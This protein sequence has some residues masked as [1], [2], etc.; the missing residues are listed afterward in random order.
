MNSDNKTTREK[1]A[2]EFICGSCGSKFPAESVGKKDEKGRPLCIP[3]SLR[4]TSATVAATTKEETAEQMARVEASLEKREKQKGSQRWIAALLLIAIPVIAIEVFMLLKNRPAGLTAP[5]VAEIEL[6][7]CMIMMTIL[8]QYYDEHGQYPPELETLVPEFW[9][10]DLANELDKF[11]YTP[12]GEDNFRLER[13]GS[14]LPP[15][16]ISEA[17]ARDLMPVTMTAETEMDNYFDR[18]NEAD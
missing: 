17:L 12:I 8:G 3:C 1:E 6:S 9:S 4:M 11:H 7:E 16:L 13:S 5:E 2:A 18:I 14:E 15:Q 10:A